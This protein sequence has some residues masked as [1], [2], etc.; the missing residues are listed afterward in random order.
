MTPDEQSPEP[1]RPDRAP[2]PELWARIRALAEAVLVLPPAAR[3]AFLDGEC[4]GD[5]GLREAVERLVSACEHAAQ[6][7]GFLREPA[8]VFAAPLLPQP[9]A[10]GSEDRGIPD[11]LQSAL[12]AKY[13]IEREVG[14]GG[15]AT[16]YLARDHRHGR[17][18]A[19][20]LLRPELGA[21]LGVER[22]LAEIQVTASLQHPNLLPLF[23]SGE[24][25]GLL[26]YVMPYV[27]GESL[28]SRLTRER[29]LPVDEAVRIAAAVAGALDYAHRHGIV[30]RDLK[31]E[32][33]LLHDGQPLVADFG[34]ALAVSKAGRERLTREWTS[35]GTPQ[36]MS[37]EQAAVD[38]TVD[39]R[40]D[41]YSLACVLYEMLTGD[42]P[43]TGS[44]VQAVL[45]RVLGEKPRPVRSVRPS[46]PASVEAAVDRA[47]AK[48]PADRFV[49]AREFADALQGRTPALL[50][51]STT[52]PPPSSGTIRRWKI[53]AIALA[54]V[55]AASVATSLVLWQSKRVVPPPVRARFLV[56]QD[57]SLA[58]A[59]TARSMSFS[60]DGSQLAYLGAR[61]PYRIYLRSMDD[62]QARAIAGT[63][64]AAEPQISPDG[65]WVA[66]LNGGSLKK[67]PLAG[68]AVETIADSVD[69]YS[70][71]DGDGVRRCLL[72]GDVVVFVK[73]GSGSV[74]GLWRTTATAGPA[75]RAVHSGAGALGYDYPDVLP[76]GH[77]VLFV[78]AGAGY[79]DEWQIAVARLDDGKLIPLGITGSN[80]HYLSGGYI[81]FGKADGKLFAVPFDARRLRV[82]GRPVQV[83]RDVVSGPGGA[84]VY[85][86]S[87][88]GTLAYLA[89]SPGF[90]LVELDRKGR[91]RPLL[92]ESARYIFPRVA[93]DGRRIAMAI[94][95]N[96]GRTD[97][98]I[99]EIPSAT[100]TRLTNGLD[101]TSPAWTRDGRRLA[102]TTTSG[103]GVMWQAWDASTPPE[104][105]SRDTYGFAITPSGDR[106]LTDFRSD[107]A[108][109]QIVAVSLDSLHHR[110]LVVSTL[111]GYSQCQLSPD[112]R[113]I[114]YVSARTGRAEVYV[115][116]FPGPG[117]VR[118]ISSGGGFEP[119]WSPTGRELF[120][121]VGNKLVSATLATTPELG[122][123]RRD[124]LFAVAAPLGTVEATYDVFP[125]GKHFVFPRLEEVGLSPVVAIGFMDDVR[126][127][128]AA[129]RQ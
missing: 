2:S 127:K 73:N 37:P 46:V 101:N 107:R 113:W 9:G 10:R 126:A 125:D 12:A 18:V 78:I 103:G 56:T 17:H 124:T 22:F 67:I 105:L 74:L 100:L 43:H 48:L 7:P 42:P 79:A 62:L 90:Q 116:P 54:L 45:A 21:L 26:Y 61:R 94:N 71:G 65:H 123:A 49:T 63:E 11:A 112:G 31:P 110:T 51:T 3:E 6:S 1:T 24:A 82:T 99:Y 122:V 19:I 52:Q 28:R 85:A 129:A 5:A 40:S 64:G 50:S 92:T 89:G 33:I 20:K 83:L 69:H 76:E 87:R 115:Q 104:R 96:T 59:V 16:V 80:P 8:A 118:Q 39:A 106:F 35:L 93:P 95:D 75:T 81:V 68:G 60:P 86:V 57:D 108:D 102:W 91:E 4:G 34:I 36:Y 97:V 58:V 38:R 120:F 72:L 119:V 114:A 15:M 47:L 109:W 77:A 121:R 29:Q 14:R 84:M 25:A 27:E 98:W 23:D 111:S 53:A 66:F 128:M 44:T 30:H 88:G 70:W 13:T 32:N 41:I 55:T 117:G